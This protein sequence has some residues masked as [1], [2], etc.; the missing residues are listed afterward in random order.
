PRANKIGI[1]LLGVPAVGRIHRWVNSSFL[2]FSVFKICFGSTR[3]W[4]NSS[5]GIFIEGSF[6]IGNFQMG[7]FFRGSSHVGRTDSTLIVMGEHE[8]YL[9]SAQDI[10]I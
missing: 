3:R 6:K 10:R 7:E 5:L 1:F 2:N 9:H 8:V 4:E